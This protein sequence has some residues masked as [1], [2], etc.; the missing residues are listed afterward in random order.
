MI[1]E[2]IT[3]LI[4]AGAVAYSA[5]HIYRFFSTIN[6]KGTCACSTCPLKKKD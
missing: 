2:I 4:L 5:Y 3:Y 1:Q 6:K